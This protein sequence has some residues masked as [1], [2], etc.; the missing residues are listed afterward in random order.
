MAWS[1]G[2]SPQNSLV[3]LT[4]FLWQQEENCLSDVSGIWLGLFK[5]L[6]RIANDKYY[7]MWSA[8]HLKFPKGFYVM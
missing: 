7:Q 4:Q 8:F 5:I 2:G 6:Q 3:D 1:E